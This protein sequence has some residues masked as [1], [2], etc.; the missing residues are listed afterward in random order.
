[1]VT[2]GIRSIQEGEV[3]EVV[4]YPEKCCGAGLC[5]LNAPAVFDQRE[6]DGIVIL[7]TS[8]PPVS[9]YDNVRRA[10]QICPAMAIELKE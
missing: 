7:L 10:K 6:D 3:M 4:I 1:V 5:V 2:A 9:E 8:K